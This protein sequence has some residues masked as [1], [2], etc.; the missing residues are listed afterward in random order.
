MNHFCCLIL[1]GI[2]SLLCNNLSAQTELFQVSGKITYSLC[3]QGGVD[4]GDE[5]IKQYPY[6]NEQFVMVR[7]DSL[8]AKPKKFEKFKTDSD[9]HF[10]LKLPE[11]IYGIVRKKDLKKLDTGQFTPNKKSIK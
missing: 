3:T 2:F 9:G 11:G 6:F 1:S 5:E 10:N 4:L 7:L 8:G